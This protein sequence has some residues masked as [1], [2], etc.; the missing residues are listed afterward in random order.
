[1]AVIKLTKSSLR[2]EEARLKLLELY[3]PTLQ[4]K[5]SLLQSELNNTK[6]EIEGLISALGKS[7]KIVESFSI[8]LEDKFILDFA[9]VKHV[10]KRYENIAGVEIPLFENVIFYEEDYFLFDTPAWMDV[11]IVRLRDLITVKEKIN[12]AVE[13][14]RALE[15]DLKDVSIRV[16][17]F[18]K[19][20]IPRAL[21]NIGKIKIFLGDQALAAVAQAKIAKLKMLK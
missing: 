14:K 12:I 15:K 11:A 6:L 13:K 20:L 17:L 9:K 1:M 18:E 4:L 3:L 21:K 19:I 8:L 2:Q 10:S 5:K 16:N 7:K